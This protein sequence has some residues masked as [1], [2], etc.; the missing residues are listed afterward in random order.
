[1]INGG[2]GRGRKAKP[3]LGWGGFA[4]KTASLDLSLMA[5]SAFYY[6]FTVNSSLNQVTESR[7]N[8]EKL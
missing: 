1:M 6:I 5:S 4:T 8:A 7:I 3:G 2:N